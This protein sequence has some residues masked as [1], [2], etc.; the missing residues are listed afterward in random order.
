MKALKSLR[1][2]RGYSQQYIADEL[3]VSRQTYSNYELG[4]REAPYETLRRLADLFDVSIDFLLSG[5]AVSRLEKKQILPYNCVGMQEV[6][7]VPVYG[8]IAAGNPI[9]AQEDIIGYEPA[10]GV[11]NPEEYFYLSVQGDSMINRGIFD[12]DLMV[13]RKQNN[14]EVGEVVIARID[15]EEATAKI[16]AMSES[17]FYLK[18]ANDA[19]DESGNRIYKDIHPQHGWEIMGVV[20]NVIHRPDK[21]LKFA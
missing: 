13:V 5:A 15:G 19:M 8:T 17:G 11:K 6:P 2:S 7:L 9:L 16:L 10:E 20:D 12:G 18:P 1:Q 3:G 4:K 14:A 21:E